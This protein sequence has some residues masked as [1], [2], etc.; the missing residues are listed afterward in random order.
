MATALQMAGE[1]STG[2]VVISGMYYLGNKP[3]QLPSV[4]F[5]VT[6]TGKTL[7]D[8]I[9]YTGASVA[10][11][12]NRSISLSG[13]T[14]FEHLTMFADSGYTHNII[15]ANGHKLTIGEGVNSICR[16]GKTYYFA[17]YGGA[18]NE[19]D[20]VEST[21]VTIR[22]GTWRGVYAGGYDS[23]VTGTA[24][25]DISGA[26]VYDSIHASRMGNLGKLELT[27]SDTTVL[28]GGIYAGSF[29]ANSPKKLGF[30][31]EGVTITLGENVVAPYLYCSAKTYGGI[32]GG[33]TLILKGTDMTKV[34]LAA[35]YPSLSA[36]Y[37][38]DWIL[39][40]LGVD[41][42]ADLT[43]EPAMELDLSG[44]DITGELTVDGA[45]TVYD[46]ATDDYD[47]SDGVFGSITGN[48][49]GTLVAKD[50]YVAAANGFH[51]FGGQYISGV[52]LRPGNAGI[53][54]TATVLADEVLRDAMETGVAVSLTDLPGTDFE[55]DEDTLYTT[56]SHG[57]L[58]QNIL[59][60]DT[61]D[62]DRAIMDI[63][64]ASYAKLP[65]GTV[66]VSD[67]NIAYSLYDVLLA[68]REQNPAAFESF[69][70]TY[71][72]ENWF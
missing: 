70:K 2:K 31:K 51:R 56:G 25:L 14:T 17:I 63:Y 13:E 58:I 50:G 44:Y 29:T 24:K 71:N 6:I 1:G 37:T 40:K 27:I 65:D 68:V 22:S 61:E 41:I 43:L 69:C 62:A 21:D 28:T 53:Y 46:S 10:A 55:T 34:P 42:S 52:S 23:I 59:K 72:I 15:L 8:G 45:L 5:P 35:R 19:G 57:V 38:T 60:G 12:I 9:R 3:Y 11:P 18:Y 7:D 54:Y 39:V 33:V 16:E 66:L 67:E 32:Q 30:V 4:G 26:T 49:T 47:V 36:S 64:A 20:V 48:V